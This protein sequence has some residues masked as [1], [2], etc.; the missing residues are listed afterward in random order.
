MARIYFDDDIPAPTARI[1]NLKRDFGYHHQVVRNTLQL[2]RGG[3]RFSDIAYLSGVEATDWSWSALLADFDNDGWQDI[4]L[5][6]G[7]DWPGHKRARTTLR[8]YKNNRDGTFSD[9]TRAVGLDVDL[10]VLA[11]TQPRGAGEHDTAD[12]GTAVLGAVGG[13]EVADL[14]A[15]AA[16]A[17]LEVIARHGRVGEHEIVVGVGADHRR[18]LV[19][20]VIL[21]LVGPGHD[22]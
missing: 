1:Y 14:D 21:A 6:N 17:D 16:H 13:V 15:I 5:V 4:L 12:P 8:L 10:G 3:R 11:Q 9:V 19:E 7:M 20:H 2:N 22:T 18:A